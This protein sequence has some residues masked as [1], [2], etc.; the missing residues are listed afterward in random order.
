VEDATPCPGINRRQGPLG[1][2]RHL[3]MTEHAVVEL[4]P[5]PK[6]ETWHVTVFGPG[7]ISTSVRPV[8]VTG[9]AA[10]LATCG[11]NGQPIRWQK[12]WHRPMDANPHLRLG[13]KVYAIGAETGMVKIGTSID[14]VDRLKNLRAT[15]PCKLELLLIFDGGML[16]ERALHRKLKIHH[17]HGE[18][19]R[20]DPAVLDA[21]NRCC[22][23]HGLYALVAKVMPWEAEGGPEEWERPRKG[24]LH[25]TGAWAELRRAGLDGSAL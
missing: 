16:V 8:A 24:R 2:H 20:P 23:A 19:F 3:G 6:P 12:R 15:S 5:A 13:G 25:S 1:N 18:W 14:M 7:R 9:L 11:V 4:I 10:E 21:L 22:T 17:D